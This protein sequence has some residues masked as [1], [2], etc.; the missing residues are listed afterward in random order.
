MRIYRC[1]SLATHTAQHSINRQP[2]ASAV[3]E[4]VFVMSKKKMETHLNEEHRENRQADPVD[5][6]GKLEC[7]INCRNKTE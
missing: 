3:S 4:T 1:T 2:A 5:D 7:V 6:A